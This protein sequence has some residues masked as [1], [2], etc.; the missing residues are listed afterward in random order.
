MFLLQHA[1][2]LALVVEHER[3]S[4]KQDLHDGLL[5]ELS[6]LLLQVSL[7]MKQNTIGGRLELSEEDALKLKAA[8]ERAVMEARNTIRDLQT[9]SS[10]LERQMR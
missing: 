10:S 1:H 6:A 7:I 5:Q 8:L 3:L 9:S 2:E 4:L